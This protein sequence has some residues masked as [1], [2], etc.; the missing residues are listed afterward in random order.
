MPEWIIGA[1]DRLGLRRDERLQ[2]LCQNQDPENSPLLS[3]ST[4]HV[5]YTEAALKEFDRAHR[6]LGLKGVYFAFELSP[7]LHDFDLSF[8][9][10]EWRVWSTVDASNLPVFIE[11]N[12][13]PDYDEAS[14]Y[15]QHGRLRGLMQTYANIRWIP[16]HGAAVQ[17][18][19]K[20]GRWDFPEEVA[21]S[22]ATR[23]VARKSC[24]PNHLG[25]SWGLPLSEAQELY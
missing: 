4:S 1:A 21:L 9:D 11:A 12:G 23:D 5:H 6:Q 17:Y 24:F 8:D 14:L 18:F 2:R 22:I 16:R 10:D 19:A 3:T 7:A 15:P 25:P 20:F 13:I